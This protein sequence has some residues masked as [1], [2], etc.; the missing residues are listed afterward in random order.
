[1]AAERRSE[2]IETALTRRTVLAAGAAGAASLAIGDPTK[3]LKR[4]WPKALSAGDTVAL[5][6]PASPT[7]QK[8]VD[9]VVARFS[10]LGLKTRP[11]AHLLEKTGLFAGPDADRAADINGAIKDDAIDAIACVRGGWGCARI[12][13]LIDWA[14]LR[15]NPKPIIGFSDVTSLLVAAWLK[16]GVVS[17]HGMWVPHLDDPFTLAAW[18]RALMTTEPLDLLGFDNPSY[19]ARSMVSGSGSVRGVL[20]GG[21]LTVLNQLIGTGYLPSFEGAIGFF[22]DTG[23]PPYRLDR[24]LTQMRMAGQLKGVKGIVLGQFVKCDDAELNLKGADTLHEFFASLR[25]PTVVN[26]PFGHVRHQVILPVGAEVEL[27]T[28]PTPA[29]KVER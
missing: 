19:A 16:A 17:Y 10:A 7:E 6:A 5:V 25:V 15:A 23:E 14:A 27:T 1:M 9:D 2:G 4:K 21:N 13:P 28:G 24:M 29:L 18:K 11:M 26:A 8:D 20:L 22:E 12:L 3:S